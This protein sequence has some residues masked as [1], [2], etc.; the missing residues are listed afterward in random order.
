MLSFIT[1]IS[2]NTFSP[3]GTW[4][5]FSRN[6]FETAL[7]PKGGLLLLCHYCAS[8]LSF[9]IPLCNFTFSAKPCHTDSYY[10]L[11]FSVSNADCVVFFQVFQVPHAGWQHLLVPGRSERVGG[12]TEHLKLEGIPKWT[13]DS[14][15]LSAPCSDQLESSI[16]HTQQEFLW[17]DD[18]LLVQDRKTKPE[19]NLSS[20]FQICFL[21][22]MENIFLYFLVNSIKALM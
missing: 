12:I 1:V 18:E 6:I 3:S 5:T 11:L 4:S 16:S 19:T 8:L 20:Q 7:W 14:V 2:K 13:F 22:C 10:F 15:V 21:L 9:P 17:W